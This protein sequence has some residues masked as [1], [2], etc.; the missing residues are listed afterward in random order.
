MN[1]SPFRL[2]VIVGSAAPIEVYKQ[3]GEL[4]VPFGRFSRKRRG[5]EGGTTHKFYGGQKNGQSE[6]END[7]PELP[8]LWY[9]MTQRV[10]VRRFGGG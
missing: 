5:P 2:R 6:G 8:I 4:N 3:A 1:C 9:T 10:I 7:A